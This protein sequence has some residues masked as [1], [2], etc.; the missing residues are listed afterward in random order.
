MNLQNLSLVP[1]GFNTISSSSTIFNKPRSTD[2]TIRVKYRNERN[3]TKWSSDTR[4]TSS[5]PLPFTSTFTFHYVPF[6]FPPLARDRGPDLNL[7][8]CHPI[9]HSV[10]SYPIRSNHNRQLV[11]IVRPWPTP[12]RPVRWHNV[13]MGSD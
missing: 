1:A 4:C 2:S 5:H 13:G 8:S 6:R 3:A 12:R 7:D 10:L 11:M 9:L